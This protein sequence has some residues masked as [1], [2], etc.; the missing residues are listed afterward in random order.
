MPWIRRWPCVPAQSPVPPVTV[1]PRSPRLACTTI[2]RLAVALE[3]LAD[4]EHVPVQVAHPDLAQVPRPADRLVEDLGARLPPLPVQR[5]DV[6]GVQVHVEE[7]G[8]DD[9]RVR[10]RPLAPVEEDRA[11][12]ARRVACL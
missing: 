9:L 4:A 12:V 7:V 10:S 2:L 6:V 11:R 5:L 8:R 3:R 1:Q